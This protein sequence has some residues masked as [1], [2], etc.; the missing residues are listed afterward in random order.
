MRVEE[1]SVGEEKERN[2]EGLDLHNVWD[3]LTPM[4]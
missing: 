2:L 3:R 1:I 4:D